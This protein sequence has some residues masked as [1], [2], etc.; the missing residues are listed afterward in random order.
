M[1]A[2]C[3]WQVHAFLDMGA[4]PVL[5]G[6]AECAAAGIL[7][8]LHPQNVQAQQ[9][10]ANAVEASQHPLWPLLFDPQTGTPPCRGV[11]NA[12]PDAYRLSRTGPHSF[13]GS[14]KVAKRANQAL[15]PGS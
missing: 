3:R 15:E 11:C 10:V 14:V 6:A 2:L 9:E 13:G 7:S 12:S 4:L 8:S 1:S 5:S